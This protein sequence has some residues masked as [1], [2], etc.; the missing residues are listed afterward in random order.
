MIDQHFDF[1]NENVRKFWEERGSGNKKLK[2]YIFGM[3]ALYIVLFILYFLDRLSVEALFI[4]VLLSF[5]FTIWLVNSETSDLHNRMSMEINLI[6]DQIN[7]MWK[8][9]DTKKDK[10]NASDR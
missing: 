1:D 2:K 7:N 5:F 9:L 4:G 10:G 8:E 3:F 6:Q